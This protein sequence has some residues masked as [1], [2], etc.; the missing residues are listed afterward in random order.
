MS[1]AQDAR[2]PGAFYGWWMVAACTVVRG[3]TAPGQTIGVSAFIDELIEALGTTRSG[4]ATAYLIGTLTGAMA[5]PFVGRWVDVAG[6]RRTMLIVASLF[7]GA[8]LFASTAQNVVMLAIAFV[9]LRM[10]GQGSLHLIGVQGIVL[11][12][13]RRRGWAL[14]ISGVGTLALMSSAPLVFT[15]LVNTFGWRASF[16]ILGVG[17]FVVVV[18]IALF[19]IVDRP[20]DIGQR[21]DGR[22]DQLGEPT[23]RGRSYTVA[24]AIRV[25]AFWTLSGLTL[26][27]GAVVTGLTFHNFD[28][29]GERGLSE[30]EAAAIFIP[31]LVGGS[32]ASF[33][34]GWATDRLP[35]RPLMF[36]AGVMLALGTFL[37]TIAEPGITAISYGLVTGVAAGSTGA[38]FPALMPKWFG[39]DHIGAIKGVATTANIGASAVGPLLLS[40]GND[41]AGTYGPV[42]TGCAIACAVTAIIAGLIPTP[43]ESLAVEGDLQSSRRASSGDPSRSAPR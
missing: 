43:R 23:A 28:L 31:Q 14:A 2:A 15:G 6:V 16:V 9:G 36:F 10:L 22:A 24:E 41:A 3:F 1:R 29:L 11:W 39:V 26:M 13:E 27:A 17:V 8:I 4:V 30:A 40:L 34:M 37:A 19:F 35:P 25:P 38:L 42:V 18:P 7:A 32:M 12:F 21:P 5:L 33:A 20:E